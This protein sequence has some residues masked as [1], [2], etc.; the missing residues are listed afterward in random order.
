MTLRR[1][2]Y[3]NP[4]SLLSF[5]LLF[6]PLYIYRNKTQ[7]AFSS[8]SLVPPNLFLLRYF[9]NFPSAFFDQSA[10]PTPPNK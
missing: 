8:F 4:L 3:L 9:F 2:Q 6:F 7:T 5:S 10:L 1:K